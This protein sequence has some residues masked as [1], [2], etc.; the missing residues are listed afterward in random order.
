MRR[1]LWH[2]TFYVTAGAFVL[3]A[4]PAS[5][6]NA[7]GSYHWE[8]YFNPVKLT[9]GDNF[10]YPVWEYWGCPSSC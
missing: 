7:W 4:M 1:S 3:T 10:K 6:D 8:R 2:L 5:G 9:L